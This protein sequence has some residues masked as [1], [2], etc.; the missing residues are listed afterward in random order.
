M[1]TIATNKNLFASNEYALL[2]W[3]SEHQTETRDGPV[4]MFSQNDLVKEHQCS[5]VTMNKWMKAL[6]KSGCLEPHKKRG[7]VKIKGQGYIDFNHGGTPNENLHRINSE[8][9]FQYQRF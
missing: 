7:K 5:P 9:S 4:V 2:A 6:C 8:P 1:I 3:L